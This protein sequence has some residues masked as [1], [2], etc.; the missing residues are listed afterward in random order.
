[1]VRRRR[2]RSLLLLPPP[3][4]ALTSPPPSTTRLSS[5]APRR[6]LLSSSHL[7]KARETAEVSAGIS[8]WAGERE[9]PN[10]PLARESSSSF[11]SSVC[12]SS[13]LLDT[14]HSFRLNRPSS[15]FF[16]SLLFFSLS[17]VFFAPSAKREREASRISLAQSA[18]RRLLPRPKGVTVAG[19][20]GS[21]KRELLAFSFAIADFTLALFSFR[22]L[23]EAK[24]EEARASLH[25]K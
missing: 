22:I 2:G 21:G 9:R 3:P 18:D 1:M 5:I 10:G 7:W 23:T 19:R 20:E 8:R 24:T 6:T 17:F 14:L 16:R 12:E 11:S 13:T 4:S 15:P 25:S